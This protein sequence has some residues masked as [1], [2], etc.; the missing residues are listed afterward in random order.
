MFRHALVLFFLFLGAPAWAQSW[1]ANAP[2]NPTEQTICATPDLAWR[3]RQLEQAYL[4]VRHLH[5][6]QAAQL[7]WIAAR[8]GCAWNVDCIRMAYDHR[9]A[10]LQAM[11]PT[12][13]GKPQGPAA[14]QQPVAGPAWCTGGTLNAAEQ[15]I[16]HNREL[17][18]MDL[19]MA[20][21]YAQV[22]HYA[23]IVSEQRDWLTARNACYTDYPCLHAAYSNRIQDLQQRYGAN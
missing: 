23:G 17:A 3:D 11:V 21:L 19:Y 7:D 5:G 8:N 6:V 1:C 12:G 16:C 13:G 18:Q 14:P 15:T 22:R 20:G 2:L 4:A 9:I 10:A